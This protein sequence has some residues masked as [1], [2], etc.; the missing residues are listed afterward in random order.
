LEIVNP[1]QFTA[2]FHPTI[3]IF[4]ETDGACS[5]NPGPGGWGCIVRQGHHAIAAYGANASTTN[6]EMEPQAIAEALDFVQNV[7]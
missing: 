3:P 6:S 5:G 1:T 7:A 2:R 4:I